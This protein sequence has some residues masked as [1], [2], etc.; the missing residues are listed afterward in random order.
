MDAPLTDAPGLPTG[1]SARAITLDD[2]DAVVDLVNECELHDTGEL[3]WERA[4]MLSDSSTDGFD[5]DH[6]WVGVFADG[7]PVGWGM[8]VHPRSAW[9]DVHPAHR[10]RGTGTWLRL[11]SERR[12]RQ[13]GA[14]RI[15]QTL[16][17]ALAEPQ[18]LLRAAGY[19]PRHTSW[20]LRADHAERPADPVPPAGVELRAWHPG[21][22][23]E[24]LAM[25]EG[26]FS[27]FADRL[28]STPATWRAMTIEREGFVPDDLILAVEGGEI[29]G[30]AFILDADEIWIDKL[31]TRR[32]V[33]HRGIG[34]ALL[35]LALQRS[36]DRGYDRTSISTDSRTGALT[37]Y[38]HVGMH[39]TRSFTNLDLDLT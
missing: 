19:D 39:V 20:I 4:D 27:E 6:D 2:V 1:C 8:I 21:D 25:F 5:R 36:F 32:D 28:P 34:R 16:D 35:Q 22:T 31:A 15:G 9:I 33:R 11:W 24:A 29:V 13:K 10:G 23:D 7:R 18:A 3:M 14:S 37:L 12:A 30:G 17:D 26:A 38:E